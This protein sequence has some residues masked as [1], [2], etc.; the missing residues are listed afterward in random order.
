MVRRYIG[1]IRKPLQK[2]IRFSP[3]PDRIQSNTREPNEMSAISQKMTTAA[4][5]TEHVWDA[6]IADQAKAMEE[7]LVENFK[8]E[9]TDKVRADIVSVLEQTT[10]DHGS[11]F[12]GKR[13]RKAGSKN[14][15]L[16]DDERCCA[17]TIKNGAPVRCTRR[18]Q[19]DEG[20]YCL[21]H[22][23]QCAEFGGKPKYGRHD[24]EVPL[25]YTKMSGG[26]IIAENQP[27]AWTSEAEVA[28]MEEA[29]IAIKKT[30]RS[31][32]SKD[33]ASTKS[34]RGPSAYNLY[35]KDPAVREKADGE[36]SV[37]KM[38]AI[39]AMWKELSEEDKRPYVEEA[40]RIKA[41]LSDASDSDSVS[42]EPEKKKKARKPRG[43]SAYNLFMKDPAIRNKADGESAKEKMGAIAAMWKELSEEDKRPYE[44]EAARLKA[45]M[46]GAPASGAGADVPPATPAKKAPKKA[47]T[48]AP[49][50]APKEEPKEESKPE[51]VELTFDSEMDAFCDD[52]EEEDMESWPVW[53]HNATKK[54]YYVETCTM[55]LYEV[56]SK[57]P[58][59]GVMAWGGEG[60]F[61]KE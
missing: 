14:G 41:E 37:E 36:S 38:G 29:G 45:E 59:G 46:I 55:T 9:M 58:A 26:I 20:D 47:K 6:F 23:K 51:P 34:K 61:T 53:V 49:K 52:D 35:M 54:R 56:E 33:G 31:R 16:T 18:C 22:S 4:A 32:K 44:E 5:A 17:L 21:T 48:D 3:P 28:R 10:D 2:L 40:A 15:E 1:A 12:K 24:E 60:V 19:K 43:A 25:T 7:F 42:S 11:I 50:K 13:G 30:K 57:A 39:A 27:I 8:M